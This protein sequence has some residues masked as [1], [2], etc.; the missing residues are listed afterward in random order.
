[1]CD[2]LANVHS[3]AGCFEWWKHTC[4][5]CHILIPHFNFSFQCQF[6]HSLYNFYFVFLYRT[7][8]AVNSILFFL[9]FI[10]F[11][12]YIFSF[13]A[14]CINIYFKCICLMYMYYTGFFHCPFGI[15][16]H[17]FGTVIWKKLYFLNNEIISWI[18]WAQEMFLC[19]M[20]SFVSKLQKSWLQ[21]VYFQRDWCM[22]FIRLLS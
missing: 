5:P 16:L 8:V 14:P 17:V 9:D 7:W 1:M 15:R 12:I 19:I 2:Y 4:L 10:V 3:L 13:A 18:L 6:I 20:N 11:N 22:Y 21:C